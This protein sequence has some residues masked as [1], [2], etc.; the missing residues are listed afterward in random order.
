MVYYLAKVWEVLAYLGVNKDELSK[1]LLNLRLS[2]LSLCII[3]SPH[4]VKTLGCRLRAT[5][6][7]GGL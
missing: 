5:V 7:S 4:S 2:K 1:R 6:W 3:R